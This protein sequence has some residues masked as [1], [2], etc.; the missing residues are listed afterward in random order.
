MTAGV[1]VD[2]NTELA[3]SEGMSF[4]EPPWVS[5]SLPYLMFFMGM[6]IRKESR[7]KI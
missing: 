6:N 7:K 3:R 2:C 5:S 1:L 4:A